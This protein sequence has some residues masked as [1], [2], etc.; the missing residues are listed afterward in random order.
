MGLYHTDNAKAHF[1]VSR[2]EHSMNHCFSSAGFILFVS[3]AL[4]CGFRMSSSCAELVPP[5]APTV[6]RLPHAEQGVRAERSPYNSFL[7]TNHQYCRRLTCSCRTF[8]YQKY[9]PSI[10]PTA[11]QAPRWLSTLALVAPWG[12][13][14]PVTGA[15]YTRTGIL[16]AVFEPSIAEE[17][18]IAVSS[19]GCT[20]TGTCKLGC[21]LWP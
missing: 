4:G 19:C 17:P 20:S 21:P 7:R 6:S 11:A 2:L 8:T 18:R 16:G 10:P 1:P 14:W 12:A 15:V 9:T 3:A 5:M 13:P